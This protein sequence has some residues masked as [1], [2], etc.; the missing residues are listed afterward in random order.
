MENHK[1]IK[2]YENFNNDRYPPLE[3]TSPEYRKNYETVKAWLDEHATVSKEG[4]L[5]FKS[6]HQKAY[7]HWSPESDGDWFMSP[8]DDISD[9]EWHEHSARWIDE[10]NN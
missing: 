1:H 8:F 4:M 6:G 10:V 9:E 5:D 2:V 3:E 7:K